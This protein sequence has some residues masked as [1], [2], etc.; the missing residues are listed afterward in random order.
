MK[1][2]TYAL[3]FLSFSC[4]NQ[5]VKNTQTAKTPVSDAKSGIEKHSLKVLNILMR[6]DFAALAEEIEVGQKLLF[7]P[8]SYIDTLTAISLSPAE[9]K[10]KAV[11]K[12]KIIWG[13]YDGI[14]GPIELTLSEYFDKF[15][16]D[17]NFVKCGANPIN[18]S[19]AVGNTTNNLKEVFPTYDFIEYYCE[20]SDKYS[21]MDW[22]AL[23][24]VYKT[25]GNKI[26]LVAIIHD[27]WTT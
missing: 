12:Q 21:F 2:L 8:Y 20:G 1:H 23:R 16:V 18:E 13:E 25:L 24:L 7:S 14:G 17:K 26:Y 10:Q 11:Q 6:K 4:A 5:E 9:L 22:G 15:V 27:Q 3:L 19:T